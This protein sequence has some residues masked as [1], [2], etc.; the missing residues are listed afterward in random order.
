MQPGIAGVEAAREK[1]WA[2]AQLIRRATQ[3][4]RPHNNILNIVAGIVEAPVQWKI[5]STG[6]MTGTFRAM[7]EKCR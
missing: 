3:Q 2:G 4:R 1:Q 5:K 6:V 7:C